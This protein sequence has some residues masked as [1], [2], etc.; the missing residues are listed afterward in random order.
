MSIPGFTVLFIWISI[1][2]AQLKLRKQYTDKPVFQVK[3]YP[4]TT[5]FGILSLSGIFIA[6]IFNKQN[7]IGTTVC[8]VTLA[9]LSFSLLYKKK[10][11]K[12]RTSIEW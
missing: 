9:V 3:W 4:Y 2:L 12:N 5:I 8:L 7:I 10:E 11:R 6:F 1:C